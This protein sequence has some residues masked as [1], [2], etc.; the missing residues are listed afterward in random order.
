M[1]RLLNPNEA[2]Q[3]ENRLHENALLQTCRKVW[4]GRQEEITSV[5]ASPE[6]V[7]CEAGW[8]MDKLIDVDDKIDTMTLVGGLWTS[9][10]IDIC[11]WTNN[12]VSI[13]DRFLI[14]SSIFRLVATT[15]SLHWHSRYC[16]VLRDAMLKVIEEK[17]PSPETLHEHHKQERQQEELTDA[18]ILCSEILSSWVNQYV[19]DATSRLTEEIEMALNPPKIVMMAKEKG[20][21]ADFKPVSATFTKAGTVLTAN[22]TLVFQFLVREKWIAESSDPDAFT[23]LFLGKASNKTIVW[24]KAKGVLRDLFKMLVD[25]NVITCP[26][27]YSY[28]QIVSSHFKDKDGNYLTDLNSGYRGKK[29]QA[30][31]SHILVLIK[32]KYQPEDE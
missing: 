29:I 16:D 21:K 31:L 23:D 2:E 30:D 14:T 7:F 6:D 19:E 3:I 22:V 10:V 28:L 12:G 20:R 26:E 9:V 4:P 17:R 24:L 13:P 5:T 1:Q 11:K 15:F 27:G 18:I 8:L 25:E 32:A